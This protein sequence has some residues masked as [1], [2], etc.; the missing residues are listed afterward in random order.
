MNAVWAATLCQY[1][2]K[3]RVLQDQFRSL[4]TEITHIFQWFN[5]Y[6]FEVFI[7]FIVLVEFHPVRCYK[8]F[9]QQR[10]ERSSHGIC[11]Q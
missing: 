5:L 2:R 9:G 3:Y 11:Q 10:T 8:F 1:A 6:E 4:K 7:V